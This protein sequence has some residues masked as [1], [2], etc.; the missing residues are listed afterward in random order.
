MKIL[1][2]PVKM[3]TNFEIVLPLIFQHFFWKILCNCGNVK[4]TVI[5]HFCGNGAPHFE[6]GNHCCCWLLQ[7]EVEQRRQKLFDNGCPIF[8]FAPILLIFFLIFKVILFLLKF[9]NKHYCKPTSN[10]PEWKINTSWLQSIWMGEKRNTLFLVCSLFSFDSHQ[11]G[12]YIASSW[13]I[14]QV[15]FQVVPNH[16]L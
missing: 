14:S 6:N 11:N 15:T 12:H 1:D 16:I 9:Y 2:V 4:Y 8:I 13:L 10:A 5:T 7:N 3:K